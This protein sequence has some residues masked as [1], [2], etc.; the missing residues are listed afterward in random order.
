MLYDRLF[1]QLEIILNIENK[2]FHLMVPLL[3]ILGLLLTSH[4]H[5]QPRCHTILS[6]FF[7]PQGSTVSCSF[8][9]KG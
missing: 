4:D 7:L 9:S 5:H 3:A 6:N 8:D 2:W 1:I